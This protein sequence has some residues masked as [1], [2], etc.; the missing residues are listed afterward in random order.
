MH[1]STHRDIPKKKHEYKFYYAHGNHFPEKGF[2]H[3]ICYFSVLIHFILHSQN[4]PQFLTS[5][6]LRKS[7]RRIA[8]CHLAGSPPQKSVPTYQDLK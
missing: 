8:S 2:D 4:S 1:K 6:D 3:Q 7:L 5:L